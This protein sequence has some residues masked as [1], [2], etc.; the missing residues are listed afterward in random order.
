MTVLLLSLTVLFAQNRT[1]SGKIVSEKG[2]PVPF[3]TVKVKG[4]KK[5]VAADAGGLFTIAVN[6]AGEIILSFSSQGFEEK[7][8][9]VGNDAFLEVSLKSTGELQEVVVTTALGIKR[10]KNKL[11]FAA[12]VVGGDDVSKARTSNFINNL[13]GKVAGLSITAPNTLGGSTNVTLRGNRTLNTSNQALFVVDGVPYDNTAVASN[14]QRRGRG[15][16]DY[17]NAAADINPDDIESITVLKG[18]AAS[19][20]YG[21]RGFN[22]VIVVTTKK[23]TTRKGLGVTINTGVSLLSADKKT[24]PKYQKQYGGGYGSYYEDPDY[25]FLYRDPNNGFMK[26]FQTDPQG[27]IISWDPEGRLVV[28]TSEDASYGAPFDPSKLVYFW[29]AFDPTSPNYLKPRPWVAAAHDPTDFLESPINFNN[30]VFIEGGS[31]KANF[32]LGYTRNDDKGILP[33]SKITKDN[34]AFSANHKLTDRLSAGAS[35]NY[36][37][38]TGLG[39]YGTGY[40]D[41]NPF[42]SF[43]QWWQVNNDVFELRDAYLR[44]KQ[45]ITWNW[46]DPTD[47]AP[48]YWDNV[49]FTRYENY[50]T[51][52]RNR[53]FGNINVNYKIN[54]WLNAMVRVNIDQY[55]EVQEERVA[56]GSVAVSGYS[57]ANRNRK[58]VNYDGLLNFDKDIAKNLNL[59]ALAG[60]N[61]RTERLSTVFAATNGGLVLPKLYS[62]SNSANPINPPTEFL[63]NKRVEG[64]FAGVTLTYKDFLTLDL[65]ERR[66]KSSTLPSD[67]NSYLYPSVSGGFIFSNLLKNV[68][69]LSYGKL[70]SNYAEVRNDAPFYQVRNSY[71]FVPAFGTEILYAAPASAANPKLKPE[72]NKSWE[73]GL[74][75]SFL[76]NRIGFDITY[77]ESKIED[78]IVPVT[79]SRATGY[80]STIRNAGLIQN[81]GIELSINATPVKIKNF[82]W[83]F[84]LNWTRNRNKVVEL[85][86]DETG[87]EILEYIIADYQGGVTTTAT[88]G[89]PYGVIKGK[90][91]VYFGDP[92]YEKRDPAMRIVGTNGRYLQ[93]TASNFIIG[94]PNPDW[95]GGISN[96][97][98][99]KNF[100]LSFLIDVKQGG[101]VFSLDMYYGLATGLYPETAGLNDLGNP[102]R[103]SNAQGGGIIRPGVDANGKPNTVRASANNFGAYGYLFSPAAGFVYDASYVKLRELAINYSVPQSIIAKLAPFKGIDFS[104]VGRNLWIIHKNLPYSDPEDSYGSGNFLGYQGNAYPATRNIAFNIKLRF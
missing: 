74:E 44:T 86:K 58:E 24:L 32:K 100:S 83:D 33:N 84:T 95:I 9:S 54:D 15:G 23:G 43:R 75:A 63:A 5:G 25:F 3:A 47:L 4:S 34:L 2:D 45:N 19:A 94:D 71:T 14:N 60:I 103:N 93:T 57:R 96:T 101:D 50:E 28:P 35:L 66:D 77:Y 21:S 6:K 62:L 38:T 67:K 7:E 102:L 39:R 91:F 87:N 99:Y 36:T 46:A 20:L 97:L 69:W 92:N 73:I 12:Q 8:V 51:D 49:Y 42:S 26:A 55:D 98:K 22:G 41:K 90:D 59:K 89:Q 82:S 88:V 65:T 72:N 68:G 16:Y 13:S 81:K 1:I 48:I 29:D 10:S 78:Q 70:R 27:N 31:D 61:I 52:S 37:K 76:K 85:F 104:L 40:D 11:P 64:I 17:G 80:N 56:I 79:V 18:P 30:S 53:Y